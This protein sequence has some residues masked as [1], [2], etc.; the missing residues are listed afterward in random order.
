MS[1]TGE[2]EDFA[3]HE[4]SEDKGRSPDKPV[5]TGLF[6]PNMFK[7]LLYKAKTTA[8]LGVAAGASDRSA[9][10][11]PNAHLF[12][13]PVTTQEVVPSPKLFVDI[14]RK[15]WNQPRS[16]SNPSGLD[17]KMYTVEQEVEDMLKL[18]AID[19][20]FTNLASS[21]IL[22]SD[23]AEGLKTEDRKAEMS[24]CKTHQAAAWAIRSAIAAS[25]F[26]RTSLLW[27]RQM[28]ACAPPGD[29]RLHQNI[30]KLIAAAEYSAD[31]TLNAAKFAS[32]VLASNVTSRRLL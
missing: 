21:N 15:Q 17:K 7:T 13:E 27:L 8:N 5:F 1:Y 31:A 3:E 4:L 14:I 25:F 10:Q 18:P 6:N 22:P 12:T 9:E 2:E 11:D 28:Q 24:V 16:L 23:S 29:V 20:P 19:A 32:R 30:N 26:N